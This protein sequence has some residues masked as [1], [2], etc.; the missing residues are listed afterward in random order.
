MQS[1]PLMRREMRATLMENKHTWPLQLLRTPDA[2]TARSTA[3]YCW[4]VEQI[5]KVTSPQKFE[6]EPRLIHK[7][8]FDGLK[9]R[10]C[11]FR[12]LK[13]ESLISILNNVP[14]FIDE[15]IFPVM[16]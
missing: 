15:I 11:P 7:V 14:W 5:L 3:S 10:T 9:Y 12:I 16:L 2:S 4:A 1:V 6:E 8:H 13:H